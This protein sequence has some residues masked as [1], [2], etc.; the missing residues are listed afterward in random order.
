MTDR[1]S[2]SLSDGI[3]ELRS[4]FEP[5]ARAP[6][7]LSQK[8]ARALQDC[9]DVLYQRARKLET[10]VSQKRWNEA[11][12]RE[13]LAEEKAVLAAISAPDS[14]VTLFPVVPRPFSDGRSGGAA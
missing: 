9:C 7:V 8:D 13:R 12:R 5:Y 2:L 14:N 10:E 4:V 11:A 1:L 6:L 3:A